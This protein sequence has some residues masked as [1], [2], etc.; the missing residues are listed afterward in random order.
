MTIITGFI[1]AIFWAISILDTR[2]HAQWRNGFGAG[3]SIIVFMIAIYIEFV[4]KQ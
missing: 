2:T 1:F 4:H 3:I